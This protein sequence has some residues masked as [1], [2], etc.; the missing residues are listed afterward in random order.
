MVPFTSL[1]IPAAGTGQ[2]MGRQVPKQFLR[3][4][5]REIIAHTLAFFQ[6]L[7]EI[8]EIIIA[9]DSEQL[10]F[11]REKIV[12]AYNFDKVRHVCAGGKNR[13]GSVYNALQHCDDRTEIILVHDAVRPFPPLDGIRTGIAAAALGRG[14]ML[15]VAVA[16]TIKQV[17]TENEVVKTLTRDNLVAVQTPQIFPADILKMAHA[18]A[19]REEIIATDEA[20]L[21]EAMGF[22]V[23]VFP[24]SRSNIKITVSEDL[25]IAAALLRAQK[26]QNV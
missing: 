19:R 2:R 22:P 8:N 7:A 15:A 25:I 17:N 12:I 20:S 1:I 4:D 5:E 14:G 10:T 6:E 26:E 3:L 11:V 9:A 21:V 18:R 13:Q 24:G 23:Q 16:D